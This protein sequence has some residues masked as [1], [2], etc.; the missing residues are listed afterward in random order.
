M[1]S[2]FSN[3]K[4]DSTVIR[5]Q[6]MKE[7]ENFLLDLVEIVENKN[8]KG[9]KK[10]RNILSCLFHVSK[11]FPTICKNAEKSLQNSKTLKLLNAEMQFVRS[12]FRAVEFLTA[13]NL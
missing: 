12:L 13:S 7:T 3:S 5:E 2:Y 4:T 11:H 1:V 8:I 6:V 10:R 9:G